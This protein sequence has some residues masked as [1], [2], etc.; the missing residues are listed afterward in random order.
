M[1]RKLKDETKG[2]KHFSGKAKRREIVL[3]KSG[4][5]LDTGGLNVS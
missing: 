4:D 1:M 2:K 5:R 3:N